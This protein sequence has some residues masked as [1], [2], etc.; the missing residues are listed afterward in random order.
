MV[1][2][3]DQKENS[4]N[5]WREIHPK[6]S[7]EVGE[8]LSLRLILK[9]YFGSQH[10]VCFQFVDPDRGV[11]NSLKKKRQQNKGALILK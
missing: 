7:V 5:I 1:G 2:Y 6:G 3:T 4:K 8:N 10:H 11:E 9:Y